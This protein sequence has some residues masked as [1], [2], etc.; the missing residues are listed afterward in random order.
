MPLAGHLNPY[1]GQ[2]PCCYANQQKIY[3]YKKY[4]YVVDG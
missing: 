1:Y 4:E 3:A 2:N